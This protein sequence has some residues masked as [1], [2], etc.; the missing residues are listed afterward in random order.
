MGVEDRKERERQARRAEI[1]C[2]AEALFSE[3]GYHEVTMEAIAERAELSKGAVYLYFASKEELFFS[4]LRDRALAFLGTLES[5]MQEPGSFIE[6]L[7]CMVQRYFAFFE[8]H[9]PF[10]K[11]IH[12]EKSRMDAQVADEFR[13]EVT[14]LFARF[15]DF[16]E[17]VMETGKRE[18]VLRD[19]PAIHLVHCLAGMLDSFVFHWVHVGTEP[20]LVSESEAVVDLFLRG[21]GK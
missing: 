6:R 14:E 18:G 1:M 19:L 8:K 12:A 5:A 20:S 4:L 21:G 17:R 2:A 3:R 10:F 9:R 15:I 11:L 13:R 7:T 16:W